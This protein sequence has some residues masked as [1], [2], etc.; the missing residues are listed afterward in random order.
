MSDDRQI[1]RYNYKARKENEGRVNVLMVNAFGL[2][3]LRQ[4]KTRQD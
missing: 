3:V 1:D 2:G 4:D